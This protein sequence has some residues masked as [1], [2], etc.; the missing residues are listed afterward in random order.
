MPP[1]PVA[2]NPVPRH[3]AVIMD[4]NGRWAAGRGLPRSAGHRAGIDAVRRVVETAP[5]HGVAA[6]TLF[7]FSSDNWRRPRAE[8]E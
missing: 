4:G 7:A 5:E 3:L 8:V 6:L 2:A 1:A